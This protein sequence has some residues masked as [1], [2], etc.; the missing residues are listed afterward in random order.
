MIWEDEVVLDDGTRIYVRVIR[1]SDRPTFREGWERLSEQSRLF[2]FLAPR[3]TLTEA[4]LD[5]L[6]DVDGVDHYAVGAV[7]RDAD[8]H[9]GPVGTARFVRYEDRPRKADF[10]I[11]VIDEYQH[12]GVGRLLLERLVEAARK[13]GYEALVA[14]VLEENTVAR[15]LIAR[16][17]PT[18]RCWNRGG[19]LRF[20]IP[21]DEE[22]AAP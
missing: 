19:M 6:T 18:V 9:E 16:V 15:H 17:A 7:T 5:Y 21:L 20:E 11:T 13:R 22:E 1:P 8:G 3:S 2:R 10:A 4:E 12:H 14:D